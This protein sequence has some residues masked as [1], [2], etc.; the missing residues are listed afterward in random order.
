MHMDRIIQSEEKNI[1]RMIDLSSTME[2]TNQM[3]L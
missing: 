2:F 1:T 3:I